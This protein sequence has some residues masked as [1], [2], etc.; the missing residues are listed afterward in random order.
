MIIDMYLLYQFLRRLVSPFEKW[1]AYKLG[2]IDSDGN[3]IKKRRDLGTSEERKAWGYFDILAANLKK[4][5]NKLPGGSS[6][7]GTFAAA[8]LLLRESEN[9]GG[10]MLSESPEIELKFRLLSVMEE[11]ANVAGNVEGLETEPLVKKKKQIFLKRKDD[12]SKNNT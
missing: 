5:L 3:V 1:E 10:K 7:I 12:K 9:D 2:I 8:L 6:K 4:L 11:I